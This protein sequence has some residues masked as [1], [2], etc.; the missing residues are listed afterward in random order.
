M[1]FVEDKEGKIL[2]IA[3]EFAGARID[4]LDGI[5]VSY[6]TWWFNVRV[7]NTEPLV[8]LNLEARSPDELEKGKRQLMKIL[9]EPI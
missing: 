8:R 3:K 5:T 4:Y 1:P 9:G 2:E 6:P 7:S